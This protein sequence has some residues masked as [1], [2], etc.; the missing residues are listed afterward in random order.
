[1]TLTIT[2]AISY[3]SLLLSS[4]SHVASC[5]VMQ[6]RCII[7]G[8]PGI[9]DAYYCRECTLQEK[10]VSCHISS[11]FFLFIL[12][13]LCLLLSTSY[14]PLNDVSNSILITFILFNL[15]YCFL[16]KYQHP[17]HSAPLC[18]AS[19]TC[20]RGCAARRLP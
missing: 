17:A 7:D 15:I 14:H 13:L 2:L 19:P 11:S 18:T 4:S 10:D 5:C 16:I 9:S 1:M 6:G 20:V 8:A 3:H 12:L